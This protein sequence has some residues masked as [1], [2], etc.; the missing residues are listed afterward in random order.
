MAINVK[1]PECREPMRFS[2][3]VAGK[4]VRCPNCDAEIQLP[5][6]AE[7]RPAAPRPA[8]AKK[9]SSRLV[10]AEPLP[11]EPEATDDS[12]PEVPAIITT[13]TPTA[14]PAARPTRPPPRQRPLSTTPL[15]LAG[16]AAVVVLGLIAGIVYSLSGSHQGEPSR[17]VAK[18]DSGKAKASGLGVVD[19][20]VDLDE[21]GRVV[22]KGPGGPKAKPADKPSPKGSSGEPAEK[23]APKEPSPPKP[24]ASKPEPEPAKPEPSPD[25][26]PETPKPDDSMPSIPAPGE[27]APETPEPAPEK[28]EP[29]PEPSPEKPEPGPAPPAPV[30]PEP[31]KVDVIKILP[32]P[33]PE[34]HPPATHPKEKPSSKDDKS[35]GKSKSKTRPKRGQQED[36]V[37]E[38]VVAGPVDPNCPMCR[39][40]GKVPFS[41]FR[42]YVAMEG[43]PAPKPELILPGR[44]CPKCQKGHDDKESL[45]AEVGRLKVGAD[46]NAAW[47]QKTNW[48]LV[49]VQTHLAS[50][51]AHLPPAE[52]QQIGGALEA[53]AKHLE[54]I[55]KSLELCVTR[56]GDYEIVIIWQKPNYLQFLKVMEPEWAAKAGANWAL[57]RDVAGSTIG[58]TSFFRTGDAGS[59][60]PTHM[61]VSMASKQ[62][63]MRATGNRAP[64]W[65]AEGFAAYC[66]NV[67]LGKNLVH[68][69]DY[70]VQNLQ[71]SQNWSLDMQRLAAASLLRPWAERMFTLPLRDYQVPDYVTSFSMVAFLIRTE[72]DKFLDMVRAI[73]GGKDAPVALTDCYGKNVEQ[74]QKGWLRWVANP[75]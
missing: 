64:T 28:P 14:T 63:I 75:R 30:D 74:L 62:Q 52:A 31:T 33:K 42:P 21:H 25:P 60:P 1:C 39:G 38:V 34:E 7:D 19:E 5:D 12:E 22:T 56:P 35:S 71:L 70:Q 61:A 11:E 51:H 8:A 29:P 53:L 18:A 20:P 9:P 23:P 46:K 69:I 73:R 45:E 59:P 37:P 17:Q 36:E 32:S 13:S 41:P 67:V 15:V 2:D 4:T 10:K 68:S 58:E 54:E 3:R 66:E 57:T 65:L 16:V 27:M 24:E 47:K 72:P 40:L 49:L 50:V 48:P 26:S 44:C 55:T 43:T 6:D